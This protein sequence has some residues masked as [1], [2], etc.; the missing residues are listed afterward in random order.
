MQSFSW[1]VVHGK[2]LGRTLGFPTVNIAFDTQKISIIPAT[3]GVEVEIEWQKYFGVW[4]FLGSMPIFE[5][6]ILDF[7]ENLYDKIIDISLLFQIRENRKFDSL[8]ALKEQIIEDI[9]TMNDY[10][11]KQKS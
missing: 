6:H 1:V 7:E 11:K 9:R 2:K 5:V 4:V 3:Y 10:I 8:D